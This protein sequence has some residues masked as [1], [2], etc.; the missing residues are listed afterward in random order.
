M[1]NTAG[2]DNSK[3]NEVPYLGP[4]RSQTAPIISLEN[5]L[6]ETEATPALPTSVLVKLRLSR[7]M[8]TKGAAAKVEIK[9]VKNETQA[10]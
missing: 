8:G 4:I 1:Q 10:K 6:P 5:M 9:Q 7:M 2:A 3:R